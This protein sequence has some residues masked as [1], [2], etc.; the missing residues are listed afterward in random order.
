MGS[1][2]TVTVAGETARA[3]LPPPLPPD[4]PLDLQ[5]LLRL[6]DRA[7]Q[8]VGRLDGLT[9][10]LPDPALLI[11][12]Y[13]RKEALLS[14][15]IEGTQ[16][17]LADL[18]LF[19]LDETPVV[20]VEDVE[21]VSSYVAAMNHGLR[22]IGEGFP[23]SLRLLREIHAILLRGG[24]GSRKA[25]GEFRRSQNWV[26]GTR[27]GN[28]LLVPP[29]H[30][31][32]MEFLGPLEGFLH[33]QRRDLPILVKAGLVHVQFETIHPFLD[34]NGRLGRL[35]VTLLL[36]VEGAMREPLLYLS[37]YLKT[38]RQI[39]YD[40]LQRVRTHGDWEA[41]LEFFLEGV[42]ETATNAAD[43]AQRAYRLIAADRRKLGDTGKSAGTT[44]KLL[45]HLQ[46]QPLTTIRAAAQATGLSIP[47]VTKALAICETLG[48]VSETTGRRRDR[49]FVYRRYLDLLA[50]GT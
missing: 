37:L 27:P 34:G 1:Y 43:A 12:L 3:Y 46:A 39:Y 15:Q 2:A 33:E 18:L 38:H 20:P 44:L 5:R 6:L 4:P 48:I 23:L 26:G 17:S 9:T 41:W 25:P 29:P 16:S 49:V 47:T 36:C 50:E 30:E 35:L 31:R 32:L 11:R 8:A 14:S 42:A 10:I 13:V 45:D 24:R 19:E 40:L 21:E 7:N 28:A 22:R